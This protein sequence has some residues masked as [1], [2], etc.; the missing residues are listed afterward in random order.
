MRIGLLIDT[1]CLGGAETMVFEIAR[2]LQAHGEEPVLLHFDS[3][4]V[5]EYARAAKLEA[6]CI[7]NRKL[8]KK[9]VSLPLFALKTA[10]W[11]KALQLDCLHT[12]LYGPITAFAPMARL[13]GLAHV[14]TLHDIYMIEEAPWR[15]RM[16]QLARLMGTR[17]VAVSRQMQGFYTDRGNFR[18]DSVRYIPNFSAPNNQLGERS[19]VRA[20]LSLAPDDIA[21]MSVGRLVA[22]KRFHILLE[23]LAQLPAGSGVKVIIIGDGPERNRLE[24]LMNTLG[25]EG[26]ATLLGERKDVPRLLAG[27][28]LFT[29]TSETEG[30]S[31]SILEALA[32]G[33]GVIATDVG[34]NSDL[35]VDG[36]N[37]YLLKGD[38]V[39]DLAAKLGSLAEDASLRESLGMASRQRL[40]REFSEDRFLKAHLEV[41][42]QAMGGH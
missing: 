37:G 34:G 25:L 42:H 18:G 23:A 39:N 12:H 27:A 22:L 6:H 2:L 32:A 10:P 16:I 21:V 13:V 30:M 24:E 40:E 7:P 38:L 26:R 5:S 20:E 17:L 11:L 8:Y 33:L 36:Q 4:Y 19:H 9:F 14:G 41:Y 15:I 28:D 1:D 31:K 35:V 29:L 3:P